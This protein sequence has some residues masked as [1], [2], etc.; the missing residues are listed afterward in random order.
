LLMA[1]AAAPMFSG[2]RVRTRIT[3]SCPAVGIARRC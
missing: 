1:R 3:W 2:L